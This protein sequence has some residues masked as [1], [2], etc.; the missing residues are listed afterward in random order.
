MT[1]KRKM[2]TTTCKFCHGEYSR[3]NITRHQKTCPMKG[4]R[5]KTTKLIVGAVTPAG[6]ELPTMRYC[7][8]CGKQLG[9]LVLA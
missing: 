1:K 6:E 5:R 7:P 8:H 4:R 2:P 3:Q 9:T